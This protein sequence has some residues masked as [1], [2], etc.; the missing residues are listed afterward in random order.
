MPNGWCCVF[1]FSDI[2]MCKMEEDVV[3][4]AKPIFYKHYVDDTY[5][6]RKKNVNDELVQNLNSYHTNIKL[7][8][9]ENP[10]K[11]LDTEI[12]RKNNTISNQVFA[13]LTKFPVHLSSKIQANYKRNAITSEL[14]RAKKIAA[15]FH[16]E[17]RRI[18][19]KFLHAGYPVKF[20]TDTFFRFKEEKEELLIP[21]WLFDETKLAF[22]RLPFA[23]KNKKFSKRF[24]SK[25]QT[26]T[27]DKVRFHII[28]N[29]RK[30]QFL[31]NN[32]DKVQHFSC[33]IYKGVCS[34][35]ADYIGE[36]IRSVK[37]TWNEH[38]SGIDKNS[39]CFKHLQEHLSDGF[40][41]S[42]LSITL[43][44]TFKRKILEAYFIKITVTSRNSQM[45]NDV[46]TLFRNGV[47]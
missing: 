43:R 29:T 14:H 26:F 18:K 11:F 25:L 10:R 4:P 20:I 30:I 13:K 28:W 21:K 15:D 41:W 45:N 22:I 34:C 19:T 27:N 32:K 12:I 17:L 42:V 39:D 3:V 8:L 44:N 38:E 23:I 6:R 1:V 9:E 33:V 7:T 37:I 16:K 2:F 46:L 40:Y 31:F 36:K 35:S 5:I 47:T 24:I